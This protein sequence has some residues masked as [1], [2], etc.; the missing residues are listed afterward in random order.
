MSVGIGEIRGKRVRLKKNKCLMSSEQETFG[1]AFGRLVQKRRAA[2]GYTQ[3][4]VAQEAGIGKN[5]ISKLERGQIDN[6][7]LEKVRAI[8]SVLDISEEDY[9]ALMPS[10]ANPTRTEIE[11]QKVS[12]SSKRRRGKPAIPSLAAA[13][14]VGVMIP[15]FVLIGYFGPVPL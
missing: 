9:E 10:P 1:I 8:S 2:H 12:S 14:L 13:I 4:F 3:L 7:G 11:A 15:L 5:E 6:P